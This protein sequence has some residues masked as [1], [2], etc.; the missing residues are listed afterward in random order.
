[1]KHAVKRVDAEHRAQRL[2][3]CHVVYDRERYTLGKASAERAIVHVMY[4]AA[5]DHLLRM[6]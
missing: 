3:F 2:L 5:V 1:M 6:R 4:R